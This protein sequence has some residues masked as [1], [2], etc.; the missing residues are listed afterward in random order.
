MINA[1]SLNNDTRVLDD[2]SF[3]FD[4]PR[5]GERSHGRSSDWK[6]Q[7]QE[8]QR[9]EQ[10]HDHHLVTTKRLLFS[11]INLATRTDRLFVETVDAI[12]IGRQGG[13]PSYQEYNA[14]GS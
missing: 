12:L 6:V 4:D 11:L 10:H 1:Q 13:T 7:V 5:Q 14:G 2:E 9:P 3:R 8:Q